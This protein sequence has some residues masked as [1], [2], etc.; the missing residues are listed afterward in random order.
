MAVPQNP[1]A[2]PVDI[3]FLLIISFIIFCK[4]F[5]ILFIPIVS[6]FI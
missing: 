6:R 1:N 4:Y 3:F 5:I 2:T